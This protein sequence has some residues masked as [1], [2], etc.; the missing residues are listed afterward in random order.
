[1]S[2][3]SNPQVVPVGLGSQVETL[4]RMSPAEFFGRSGKVRFV[5]EPGR[6]LR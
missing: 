3:Y 5:P 6:V 1:M 4:N 2:F